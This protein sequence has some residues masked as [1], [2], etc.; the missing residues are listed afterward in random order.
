[1]AQLSG[2]LLCDAKV[3]DSNRENNVCMIDVFPDPHKAMSFVSLESSFLSSVQ[4]ETI[5]L[6][7][8]SNMFAYLKKFMGIMH[9]HDLG[10]L[11]CN[12]V[13][14]GG[15]FEGQ[16]ISPSEISI[17]F[18]SLIMFCIYTIQERGAENVTNYFPVVLRTTQAIELL[19]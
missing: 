7:F 11:V 13:R 10:F 9:I 3:T 19:D 5:K 14:T 12:F 4:V 8:C 18:E 15:V 16:Y 1:M 2:L 17:R 6:H